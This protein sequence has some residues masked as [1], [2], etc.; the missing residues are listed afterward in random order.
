MNALRR[1][2]RNYFLAGILLALPFPASAFAFGEPDPHWIVTDVQANCSQPPAL[3][4]DGS[5]IVPVGR[6]LLK[7]RPDGSRDLGFGESGGLA[8]V[9]VDSDVAFVQPLPD[10]RV[11]ASNGGTV[12]RLL[13]DGRPDPSFGVLGRTAALNAGGFVAAALLPDGGLVVAG[14]S[15]LRGYTFVHVTPDGSLAT[16]WPTGSRVTVNLADRMRAFSL[17]ASGELE[18]AG[19]GA[20]YRVS[21][22]PA[23][24]PTMTIVPWRR[25]PS[26][27]IASWTS[28]L[29]KV[30]ALGRVVIAS[31]L[32]QAAGVTLTRYLPDGSLDASFGA[33]GVA[34]VA[35]MTEV[36]RALPGVFRSFAAVTALWAVP[37]GGWTVLVDLSLL[38]ETIPGFW[39]STTSE[40]SKR[41]LRF[42]AGGDLDPSFPQRM[43]IRLGAASQTDDGGFLVATRGGYWP[44]ADCAI[45][46]FRGDRIRV[47]GTLVEYYSEALDHYFMT[48]EGLEVAILDR[49][50]EMGW[51]RT[52]VRLGAW[53]VTDVPG[54]AH[55]CR[56]Y[57]DATG[58]PN[59][60]FYVP[61][62][63]GCDW[64]RDLEARAPRGTYAWRME[65]HVFSVREA[66]GGTCPPALAPVYRFYNDGFAKGRDPNHR[67]SIDPSITPQMQARGWILE[68]IA[69]CVPPVSRREEARFF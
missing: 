58:G 17:L 13:A 67:Y 8:R 43:H 62:G 12:V 2:A 1:A 7:L 20:V 18:I 40:T 64:L 52:G 51:K 66:F 39:R 35:I 68:G 3:L 41:A 61:E 25:M 19:T 29:V 14:A 27:G 56:F 5:A 30:D 10:G 15:D 21:F 11:L 53:A 34:T 60:H 48:L 28:S 22:S 37:G 59:S 33:N 42:T 36:E 57:G 44:S 54:A 47:E 38:W 69:F 49:H 63:T 45:Q 31:E 65:G 9:A 26:P 46:R 50:P 55:V 16:R 24:E 32:S 23:G 6:S 4:A